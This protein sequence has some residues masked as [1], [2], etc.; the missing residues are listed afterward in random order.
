MPSLSHFESPRRNNWRAVLVL[1]AVFSLALSVATRYSTPSDAPGPTVKSVQNHTY[2]ESKR[3]RLVKD[4]VNWVPPLTCV[5]GLSAPNFYPRIAPAGPPIP[6][7]V[8]EENVYNRPPP[9]FQSLSELF[10]QLK[11][12]PSQGDCSVY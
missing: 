5:D 9:H 11:R 2:P 3:Q 8:L 7:L 4:A 12:H 6:S 1:V 10:P